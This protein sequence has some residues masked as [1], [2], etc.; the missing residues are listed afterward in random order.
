VNADQSG[1]IDAS[2]ALLVVVIRIAHGRITFE[3]HPTDG[4]TRAEAAV[5]LRRGA[6][7]LDDQTDR[8]A[9]TPTDHGL[10]LN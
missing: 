3:A 9:A 4:L 2:D 6:D 10:S 1:T 7:S 8:Q 5:L